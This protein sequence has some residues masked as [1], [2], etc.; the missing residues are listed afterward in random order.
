MKWPHESMLQLAGPQL[1]GFLDGML[2]VVLSTRG[3]CLDTN[4]SWRWHRH[5][6]KAKPRQ[7][8][9][10]HIHLKNERVIAQQCKVPLRQNSP[11]LSPSQ[12]TTYSSFPEEQWPK[13]MGTNNLSA[14]LCEGTNLTLRHLTSDQTGNTRQAKV[15]CQL[16]PLVHVTVKPPLLR[17]DTHKQL[18]GNHF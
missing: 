4:V 15:M 2:N 3:S 9:Y 5:G 11:P 6:T 16:S 10:S 12:N 18:T 8:R 17:I 14:V 13:A 1:K 7:Q